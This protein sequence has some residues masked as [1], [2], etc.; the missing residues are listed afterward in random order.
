MEIQQTLIVMF[1]TAGI[2]VM[3]ALGLNY[4]DKENLDKEMIKYLIAVVILLIWFFFV[5]VADLYMQI[6]ELRK[7]IDTYQKQFHEDIMN[8]YIEVEKK[9]GKSLH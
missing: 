5:F 1:V 8:K 3:I 9:C 2:I 7:D 6:N 4:I